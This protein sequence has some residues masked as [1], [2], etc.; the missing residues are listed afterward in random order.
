MAQFIRIIQI[1]S[2]SSDLCLLLNLKVKDRYSGCIFGT[3]S[4][5]KEMRLDET[6]YDDI[7]SDYMAK[8]L[9]IDIDFSTIPDCHCKYALRGIC[10]LPLD[11][12]KLQEF[13]GLNDDG[14]TEC[15]LYF[16]ELIVNIG[17]DLEGRQ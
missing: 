3:T 11:P 2:M 14:T 8:F 17:K 6:F 7:P 13:L 5:L 4:L 16:R 9:G 10:E 15:W 1:L 12:G